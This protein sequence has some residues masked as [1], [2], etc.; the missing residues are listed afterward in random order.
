MNNVNGTTDQPPHAER[1]EKRLTNMLL[2]IFFC[3]ILCN[4]YIFGMLLTATL[5]SFFFW[6]SF[7]F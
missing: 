3:L 5:Y 1:I 7:L 2:L 4:D 6:K